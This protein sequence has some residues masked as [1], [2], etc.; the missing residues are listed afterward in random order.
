MRAK[1]PAGDR[2]RPQAAS[3]AATGC[4]SL[5]FL[6]AEERRRVAGSGVE[7]GS[8][9]A[10]DVTFLLRVAAFTAVSACVEEPAASA[11]ASSAPAALAASAAFS[12]TRAAAWRASAPRRRSPPSRRR[13]SPS[14][15]GVR[16]SR[17]P[18][19][20]RRRS[21]RFRQCPR[22]LPPRPPCVSSVAARAWPPARPGSGCR[23]RTPAAHGL[24]GLAS[25]S[26]A[27]VAAGGRRPPWRQA[28][29]RRRASPPR[30]G[31]AQAWPRTWRMRP[32]RR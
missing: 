19:R 16:A 28:R 8:S 6:A 11:G 20:P 10:G 23:G 24:G 22:A 5:G 18:S 15:G 14:R 21:R 4:G 1:Y 9:G 3:S 30:G 13:T 26:A 32:R 2:A 7:P 27:G 12:P 25:G 17:A 29:R 31:G